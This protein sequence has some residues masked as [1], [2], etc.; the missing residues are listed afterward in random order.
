MTTDAIQRRID[1][2]RERGGVVRI[3]RGVYRITRTLDL[4]QTM[5]LRVEGA[6]LMPSS[7]EIR[8]DGDLKLSKPWAGSIIVWDGP[9]GGDM[10]RYAGSGLVLGGISLWGQGRAG[11]G[12]R[13]AYESGAAS[14][15][16]YIQSLGVSG[17]GVAVQCGDGPNDGNCADLHFGLLDVATCGT[18]FK[19]VNSQGVNY[20]FDH[21]NFNKTGVLFHFERGGVFNCGFVHAVQADTVLRVENAGSGNGLYRIG[22]VSLDANQ[23]QVPRL[24]DHASWG[25]ARVVIDAAKIDP[26]TPPRSEALVRAFGEADITI[27]NAAYLRGPLATLTTGTAGDGTERRARVLF[28]RCRFSVAPEA[29]TANRPSGVVEL[30]DCV[31][32]RGAGVT[33]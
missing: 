19:V 30:H 10:L 6:G 3:P 24:V 29:G 5:G 14:G 20:T 16:A 2:A 13:V 18:G 21:A 22:M 7:F 15:H 4:G 12:L 23:K 32:S 25:P 11:V 31:D 27:R 28:E 8:S 33:L 17:C 1:N 26:S 9:E